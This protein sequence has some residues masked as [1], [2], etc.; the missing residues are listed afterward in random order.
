[1]SI[2]KNRAACV[3]GCIVC[4]LMAALI[5]FTAVHFAYQWVDGAWNA[6]VAVTYANTG[7]YATT[8]PEH[9]VFSV[10]ITT[11]QT[12]L[13]PAALV[14]RCFGVTD[15]S[16]AIV[17]V[18]YM[19]AACVALYALLR[20]FFADTAFSPVCAAVLS[21]VC[22][23]VSF[24]F[25]SLYGRYAYQLLGEG[26]ALLFLLVACLALSSYDASR[27]NRWALLCGA[28]LACAL[29][30]K[31][32]AVCFLLVFALLIALECLISRRYPI[33]LIFWLLLGF[34]AAF[35]LLESFKFV[36]LGSSVSAYLRW[37][38]STIYYSFN[39]SSGEGASL[40]FLDRVM[41][42]LA[43][44]ANLFTQGNKIALLLLTL[45]APLCYL[46]SAIARLMGRKDPFAAPGRFSL[47]ALG[48][49]GDGF[50]VASLL[51]TSGG[52]FLERRVL[53]HG[54]C[55]L[56]FIAAVLLALIARAFTQRKLRAI[57]AGVLSAALCVTLLPVCVKGAANA[58]LYAQSDDAQRSRDVH[59]FAAQVA[60]MPRD[61]VYYGCGWTFA[62]ETALLLDLPL[63]DIEA[64]AP[65][66]SD[67]RAHYLLV[68]SYPVESDLTAFYTLT[69]VYQL[70]PGEET[71]SVYRLEPLV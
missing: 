54:V 60:Q 63:T 21:A 2:Q 29:V 61:A 52:M 32:V 64:V 33:A 58:F 19:L 45:V 39:L 4:A 10:P 38:K 20:R 35:A 36:Q 53:L 24:F 67:G 41:K 15:A 57:C 6:Q 13:L 50:I 17:P 65:D 14:F 7:S 16:A 44:A 48:L 25:F 49:C 27:H 46:V 56:A 71:F 37:W 12:V 23:L 40:S 5:L 43:D 42:N 68:E 34:F 66:F 31:T 22:V 1:M 30:T 8:Y 3:I 28:M 18:L 26:A 55:F 51:F 69:S 70:R 59:E 47:L 9:D 62:A 11:G